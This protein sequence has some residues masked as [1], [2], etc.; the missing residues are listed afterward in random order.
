MND[1]FKQLF[2]QTL[3]ATPFALAHPDRLTLELQPGSGAA[4][5]GTIAD[6]GLRQQLYTKI[7]ALPAGEGSGNLF[8]LSNGVYPISC[9]TSTTLRELSL[10]LSEAVRALA[11]APCLL[12][13]E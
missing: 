6:A 1:Q 3:A 5:L 7:F 11:G 10:F 12:A 2:G 8:A 13:L 9:K 4:R